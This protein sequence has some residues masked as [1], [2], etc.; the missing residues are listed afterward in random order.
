MHESVQ[1]NGLHLR[2][3]LAV[4]AVVVA[5]AAAIFGALSGRDESGLAI[6][7]ATASGGTT[8][9]L[10]P[11]SD[12]LPLGYAFAAGMAAAVNPCGF[13]LLPTYLGLYL[14]TTTKRADSQWHGASVVGRALLVSASMTLAFVGLFGAMGL[15]LSVGSSV[16]GP[17]L[18]WVSLSV[19]F[20]LVLIGG[21]MLG[22][23]RLG[24]SGVEQAAGGI[25][26]AAASI[27]VM[28]YAAYGL[29]FAL[30]SLGCTLPLFLAVVGSALA[31][32]GVL[33]GLLEF[34]LY[35]LGMGLVVTVLTV[36]VAMFGLALVR[37][38][39]RLGRYL[40]PLSAFLLLVT[41]AYVV[42]YW[43]SAGGLL[44]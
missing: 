31:S 42:Y 13:A 2:Q 9:A 18:P 25:G 7:I 27:S 16:V 3:V 20:V 38:V 39:R 14:G 11:I 19:G 37:R 15:V 41:G 28:G 1:A 17:V 34:L 10:Q 35:A 32:G 30:S 36:S 33:G 23:G 5:L 29:A 21:F 8:D 24:F 12:R 44:G 40:E 6:A 4:S 26:G 22:G 43:L